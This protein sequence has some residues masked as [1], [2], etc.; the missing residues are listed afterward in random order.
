[1]FQWPDLVPFQVFVVIFEKKKR[2]TA[3]QKYTN[4]LK[5]N[6][7]T[8]YGRLLHHPSP[9][10]AQTRHLALMDYHNITL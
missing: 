4:P 9:L 1:M 3:L 7:F 6:L 2:K 5:H 8:L 10:Q